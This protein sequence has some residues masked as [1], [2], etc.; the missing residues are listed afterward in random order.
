[1]ILALDALHLGEDLELELGLHVHA[2]RAVDGPLRPAVRDGRARRKLPRQGPDFPFEGLL[3]DD[4]VYQA[5]LRTR[6]A[7]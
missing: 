1:M 4:A 6:R 5:D 2:E 3:R 7:F